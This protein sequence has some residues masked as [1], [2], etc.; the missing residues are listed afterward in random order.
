ML[1]ADLS[2][3]PVEFEAAKSLAWLPPSARAD[4]EV[5]FRVLPELRDYLIPH[6]YDISRG[7]RA[8]RLRCCGL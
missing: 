5:L 2:R 6:D 4:S 1:A 8:W 3:A 7:Y